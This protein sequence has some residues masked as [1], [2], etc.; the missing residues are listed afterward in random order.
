MYVEYHVMLHTWF[1]GQIGPS[2]SKSADTSHPLMVQIF[3]ILFSRFLKHIV[4]VDI[5]L[6]TDTLQPLAT[7]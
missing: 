2:T 7:I 1:Y 6:G 4:F 3:K 5:M